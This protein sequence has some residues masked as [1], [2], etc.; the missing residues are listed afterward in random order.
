MHGK[1]VRFVA[2]VHPGDGGFQ[3]DCFCEFPPPV[4]GYGAEAETLHRGTADCLQTARAMAIEV[5][6]QHGFGPDEIVWP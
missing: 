3:V 1:D 2:S 4:P 6:E 5:A